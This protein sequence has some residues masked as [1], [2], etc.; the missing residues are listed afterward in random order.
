MYRVAAPARHLVAGRGGLAQ[1]LAVVGHVHE[2]DERVK[3]ALE[4]EVLRRG[5]RGVRTREPLGR[6]VRRRD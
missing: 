4:R 2:H 6:G 5:Q 1:G 3:A